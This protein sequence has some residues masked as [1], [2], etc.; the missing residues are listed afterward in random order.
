MNSNQIRQQFLS[1]YAAKGHQIVP[2]VPLIAKPPNLMRQ[3][4]L[5][6]LP[7][8]PISLGQRYSPSTH[9]TILQKHISP[10]LTVLTQRH[11]TFF[12][13]LGNWGNYSQPQA[14]T[15]A[16]ELCT[17]IYQLPQSRLVVSVHPN[18]LATF[19]FW[20]D[21]IGI[22]KQQI[23]FSQQNFW[24]IR[25]DGPSGHCTR[26]HYDRYPEQ[27]YHSIESLADIQY[28]PKEREYY[29]R[30]DTL[31]YLLPDED[32]RF[33]SFYSLVSMEWMEFESGPDTNQSV[34]L[35]MSYIDAGMNVEQLAMI[36]QQVSSLYE[37]DLLFP[38][39]QTLAAIAVVDYQQADNW[40]KINLKII[41]DQIRAAVHLSADYI[42]KPPQS[43]PKPIYNQI[44]IWMIRVVLHAQLLGI[45]HPFIEELIAT[46]TSLGESFY[47]A[48][49]EQQKQ[50][51]TFLQQQESFL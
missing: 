25:P 23:V 26:I 44:E 15:W 2:T 43:W 50:I 5:W 49:R 33:L 48:L 20:R 12:E 28:Q 36:L 11:L 6:T 1:F 24:R 31:H 3:S 46:V 34:G 4:N 37:T 22:P 7:F 8:H 42:T 27:G 40:T 30:P 45:E 9:S 17:E 29:D 10:N 16:W 18:D 39:I 19:A 41:A 21:R 47:P 35:P 14:L 32:F 51:T 13:M 38:I